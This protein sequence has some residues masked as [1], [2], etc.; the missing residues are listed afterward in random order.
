MIRV[1]TLLRMSGLRNSTYSLWNTSWMG[2][3]SVISCLQD[4]RSGWLLGTRVLLG[5]GLPPMA[6]G[7]AAEGAALDI[8]YMADYA[9][10]AVLFQRSVVTGLPPA[11]GPALALQQGVGQPAGGGVAGGPAPLS[12]E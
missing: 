7:A 2:H 8:P 3:G 12:P 9:I 1:L 4:G 11:G 6:S 10:G 5:R